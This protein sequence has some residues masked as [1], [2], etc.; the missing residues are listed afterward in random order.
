MKIETNEVA[1]HFWITYRNVNR[2]PAGFIRQRGILGTCDFQPTETHLKHFKIKTFSL[3]T[4]LDHSPSI[5]QDYCSNFS[6]FSLPGLSRVSQ[7][8]VEN[9]KHLRFLCQQQPV[10]FSVPSDFVAGPWHTIGP[11]NFS[12]GWNFSCPSRPR[13]F[14]N[15]QFLTQR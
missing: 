1:V 12:K 14:W 13:N 8:S 2:V 6:L 11:I 3:R 5:L 7:R 10:L 15:F 9:S 4:F